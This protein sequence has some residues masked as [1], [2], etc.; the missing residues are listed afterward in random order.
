MLSNYTYTTKMQF[1]TFQGDLSEKES[2]A[3]TKQTRDVSVMR[4]NKPTFRGKYRGR[5]GYPPV[6]GETSRVISGRGMAPLLTGATLSK[7]VTNIVVDGTAAFYKHNALAS[8]MPL[9]VSHSNIHSKT[10]THKQTYKHTN[11]YQLTHLHPLAWTLTFTF[12]HIESH[13]FRPYSHL[14]QHM[15]TTHCYTIV[16]LINMQNVLLICQDYDY[17][18]DIQIYNYSPH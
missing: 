6:G 4:K 17:A 10:N 13:L 5:Q 11:M 1:H 16:L 2:V 8:A 18:N 15:K 3:H 7:H 14:I 9:S 12:G